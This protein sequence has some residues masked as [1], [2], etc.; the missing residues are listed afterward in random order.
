MQ[1]YIGQRVGKIN[2]SDS[3]N[4]NIVSKGDEVNII[5][6]DKEKA[7]LEGDHGEANRL[8]MEMLAG[9]GESLGAERLIPITSAHILGHYGGLHQAGVD[10]LEKLAEEGGK[11]RVPTT[12]D[13]SSVDFIRWEQFKIPIEYVEGQQ[14][15][16]TAVEKLGVIPSWSCTPYLA[17]NVP[18][19]GQNVA[20]AES[21][22]VAYVNS[23]IGARTNRTPFGLDICAA[24][25]GKIPEFGL[26]LGKNRR[27]SLL[28][29]V[30]VEEF[31]DLDYHTLGAIVG[32]K[33]GSEIP[34]IKGIPNTVTNDQLKSFGAAA[35]SSGSV[36]LY[37]ALGITP[38]AILKDPFDG[39]KPR[40]I[41]NIT[42]KDFHDMEERISTADPNAKIDMV[43]LG[44]PLLSI[45][46][47]KDIYQKMEG[48]KVKMDVYFWIY[49][50]KETYDLGKTM[51]LISPL[52]KAGIWFSTQ[53]CATISPVKV[54]RFS[55][56]MTNSAK[57]A[58]VVPSE[59]DVMVT[60]RETEG[61]ILTATEPL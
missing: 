13:P 2:R 34:V 35:A 1:Q 6:A 25:I 58:L 7:Y 28:F 5:L 61:C 60:Y 15:L 42:R 56:V 17:L 38:E 39:Q 9:V 37:H 16:L 26:Y 52:E 31:S 50:P 22:A 48:S 33:S 40:E 10:F 55:H 43:A 8:A 19:F 57:C 44:C 32:S 23:V 47:L 11:C 53:T 54:W 3:I 36:A 51:G 45:E 27:G 21:S 46:E 49:L 41:F 4:I 59:H 14:K 20:W 30:K 24:L 29:D 12:V 18:R